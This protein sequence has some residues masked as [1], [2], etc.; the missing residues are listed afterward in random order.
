M[1][2]ISFVIPTYNRVAWL[3]QS[4]ESCLGQTE[5]DVEVIVVDDCSTD[6]TD[7]LLQHY[8]DNPR[9]KLIKND[10]NQGAGKSRNI[11]AAVASSDII[12]VMDSDDICVDIRAEETLRWFE[13]NPE[14]ELVTFPYITVNYFDEVIGSD[15]GQPFDHEAFKKNGSVSYFS[16]PASAHRKKP[17]LEMGGYIKEKEGLTDDYQFITKWVES[18]RKIDFCS[19]NGKGEIPFVT[20]HRVLPDS[21]MAK[22]RGWKKEWVN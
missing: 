17:F 20:L 9:V 21:I 3:A 15:P 18:G 8:V 19:D 1:S 10:K 11:G 16:N 14:S 4:I 7:L 13:K 22:I 2:R 12:A 5:K 6:G